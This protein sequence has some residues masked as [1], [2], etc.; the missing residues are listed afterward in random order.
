MAAICRG[1]EALHGCQ[2]T[3]L[4]S[5][6]TDSPEWVEFSAVAQ[7]LEDTTYAIPLVSLKP[8]A[9]VICNARITPSVFQEYRTSENSFVE[10]PLGI[11][12]R[13]IAIFPGE[14]SEAVRELERLQWTVL[15]ITKNSLSDL[16]RILQ[17]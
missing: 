8:W 7:E 16:E 10:I 17:Q 14:N 9:R 1:D 6:D 12:E 2:T 3:P 4:H 15:T 5:L 11:M 13:K